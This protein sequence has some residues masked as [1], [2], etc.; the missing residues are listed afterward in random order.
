MSSSSD[1]QAF[2]DTR[3]DLTPPPPGIEANFNAPNTNGMAYI[4]VAVIGI[5]LATLFTAVRIY[6]KGILTRSL[7]W[8][9]RKGPFLF[10]PCFSP[11]G[12]GGGGGGGRL[13][14]RVCWGGEV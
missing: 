2:L 5:F 1:M 6:T 10:S 9:D 13:E 4:I 8:D 3:P 11:R 7:G 14:L 12:R